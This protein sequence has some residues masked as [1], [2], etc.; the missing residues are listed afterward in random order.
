MRILILII[1]LLFASCSNSQVYFG[2]I[3]SSTGG[4]GGGGGTIAGQR[5]LIYDEFTGSTL[6]SRWFVRRPD[7]QTLTVSGGV[8]RIQTNTDTIAAR[9][10]YDFSNVT[11]QTMLYDTAY[12]LTCTRNYTEEIK[13]RP[14]KLNDTTLGVYAGP[15]SPFSLDL[16]FS[17]FAHAQFS[18]VDT[19]KMLA[20]KDTCFSVPPAFKWPLTSWSWN[21]TDW[22]ILRLTVFEGNFLITIKNLTSNDSLNQ[23]YQY[24]FTHGSY[25]KRP[26]YFR[27]AF[28]AMG[29]TDVDIDYVLV[30]TPEELNPTW[31][32]LSDSRGTGYNAVYADSAYGNMLK[33]NTTDSVQIWAGGGMGVDE[34]LAT[35][36]RLRE[37]GTSKFILDFGTNNTFNS[38]FQTKFTR[39]TDSITSWGATYYILY[40][41]NHGDPISGSGMNKWFKDNFGSHIADDWDTGYAVWSTGNGRMYDGVHHTLLGT[42]ER[43]VIIKGKLIAF[44]PL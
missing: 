40:Q 7:K 25:P 17:N 38:D 30:T 33:R 44:F 10:G 16:P 39:I 4:G 32:I 31:T 11:T 19:L 18:T 37:L 14:R 42:Q 41:P 28:G 2:R 15:Y 13:F 27:F 9:V 35:F 36:P 22:Y 24:D 12:G 26:N 5:T 6:N 43:Y 8:L 1:S 34:I 3:A 23:Y 20:G 21:T 29:R